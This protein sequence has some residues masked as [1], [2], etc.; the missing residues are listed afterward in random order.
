MCPET[1]SA[2]IRRVVLNSPDVV[3]SWRSSEIQ[4]PPSQ[5]TEARPAARGFSLI[6]L[7]IVV[8]IVGIFMALLVPALNQAKA[9]GKTVACLGQLQQFAAAAQMYS[10]DNSGY[11]VLNPT[12]TET[13]G[14]AGGNMQDAT[15][16]TN[17]TLLRQGKLFP[18]VGRSE[19]FHCPADSAPTATG[20]LRARSYSMNSWIGSRTMESAGAVARSFRTFVRD[21]ELAVGG[22]AMLWFMADEHEAT[23]DDGFFLVTMDDS[24]PFVSLPAF[25]H[26]NGF[27][28]NFV[29][30]HVERW[31]L[32]DSTTRLSSQATGKVS[33]RNADWL[34]LKQETTIAE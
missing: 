2:R 22:P 14:W 8:A 4:R 28:L 16:V 23:I 10:G 13:N 26:Q 5:R 25:R 11:L 33:P 15:Q 24:Q 32:R 27:A 12:T 20:G 29:D 30:G 21:A 1:H 17:T 19:L 31:K 6:E 34:R 3:C 18:Y 9:K 7:L